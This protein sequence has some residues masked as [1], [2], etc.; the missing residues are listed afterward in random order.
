MPPNGAITT[1]PRSRMPPTTPSSGKSRPKKETLHYLAA[2]SS[3]TS[4]DA[5]R[6]L[7]ERG[8]NVNAIDRDGATPLHYACTHD[9]VAMAQLLLTFGADPMSAD[10]LGRTAYSIAKGNTLR[11]L[12]RY[13]KSS[14]RQRLGFFRRFFACHSRNETFF[15]V[16]N[17]QEVAPL[18]PTALAEAASI[19]FN[20]GN[21]LTNSYR[22]AKKK[23]RATFHAIRRSRSN[24]TATLQDV[25]LTSEGIR[26]VTT[27]SRRAPKATVYAKRSMSVS[28]LLLIPDRRDIKNEDVKTRGSPVKKTRG[29][30]RS[31]TPEAI[32]NPRKQRTPVNH[33]KRSKSQETKL[34]AMPSPN[35]MAYYNT[36]R[37]RNAGLR[38]APSAPPLSP[39]PAIAAVKTPKT[40]TTPKTSKG[41]SKSPANTT[42]YFTA[43]ESLELLGNNM[44]KLNIESKS[45]KSSKLKTPS[46]P[47]TSSS[48][49]FSSA[50]DD[51]EAEV[52]TPTTVDDGE[53]RKI[54]RLREGE[55]KSELKK[56]GIS[57]AGPL[58]ARTRRLYEKKLLIERRKITNRGYSPDADVVSCRNSPQL[59]LVLRN[60][61]LPADFASRARKCDENVRSEFSGNGFGYNAFC[62]LIMDPRILGSNV[63]NL[64]LETFVRSIFYVGKGSKNR[65][66]AHFI[67]ARN[68]RRD[69]LDKLKTCEKLKT[70]DELWTLGFGIPRHEI[71]HGVSD[72]EAFVREASIIEAVKLKNLRNKKAGE[73]HGT[74]KSW[75]NI[76]K[77]EYGT[78]LLDRALSTLKLEGIRLITEDNLPDSLYPY[79]NNRR[80]AGGGR[81]PKTPK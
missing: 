71:S 39:E 25:V 13:K 66:L 11:F 28:D 19:S 63:E 2:S 48:T 37:A 50:E 27:P 70:I 10:K 12:R 3:T 6:T 53:I 29:T 43:D 31:R 78:F 16:R 30:G 80:G 64:T 36:S 47:T 4:V 60:G 20:R 8:A 59:E 72:E 40:P 58:D 49:S 17:N 23:I 14:N 73:F 79:V 22:C 68:E 32:L 77:S 62:Y 52:S 76:T 57:P 81:T 42:A 69:K 18:R 7:L 44:E 55:L 33:H 45:A 21:V 67:D 35:S 74:T 24:S 65:P 26:T 34:V 75:D 15:I 41:R 56:F 54:R 46:K 51:K 61:F 5:A 38:P 9:N 1:T